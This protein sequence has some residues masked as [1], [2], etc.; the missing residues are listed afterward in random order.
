M[1]V[2]YQGK[3]CTY[4]KRTNTYSRAAIPVFRL[5][6]HGYKRRLTSNDEGCPCFKCSSQQLK[7]GSTPGANKEKESNGF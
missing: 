3:S 5:C 7:E 6:K 1:S 4:D 2:S